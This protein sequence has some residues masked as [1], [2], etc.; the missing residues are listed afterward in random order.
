MET[1]PPTQRAMHAARMSVGLGALAGA[2]EL[3]SISTS[4]RQPLGSVDVLVLGSVMVTVMALFSVTL[5]I[6]TAWVHRPLQGADAAKAMAL[7]LGLVGGGLAAW[8]LWLGAVDI[9]AREQP[10]GAAAMAVMPFGFVGVVYY[11]ARYLLRRVQAGHHAP[12][13]WSVTSA[14][15]TLVIVVGCALVYPYRDTG[16]GYA[17]EGD[18]SAVVITVDGL[19]HDALAMSSFQRVG[20]GGVLFRN[21]VT[22]TPQ[23]GP[24]NATVWTGLHPLRH[25][26]LAPGTKLHRGHRTVA[27]VVAKEGYATAGFV[28]D[29]AVGAAM[30]FSQGFGLFDDDLSPW[31]AGLGHF[32][33]ARVAVTQWPRL[34]RDRREAGRTVDRFLPWLASHS[35]TPF[36]AWLHLAD[37]AHAQPGSYAE[38]ADEVDRAIN[39]VLDALE[40]LGLR[41]DTVLVLAG[42]FGAGTVERPAPNLFEQGVRVPL[43]LSL[44]GIEVRVPE[45]DAQVRL[46]DIAPT[47]LEALAFDESKTSEGVALGVYG[48]GGRTATMWCSL[49]AVD[50]GRIQFGM[51]N[52]GVKLIDAD[53]AI[54]MYDVSADPD[55]TTDLSKEQPAVLERAMQLLATE[56]AALDRLLE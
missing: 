42:T 30:D 7:H 28:S 53:G 34:M 52:S 3:V 40:A 50:A 21:A 18:R 37:P 51:R 47:L 33:L 23:S 39:R 35:D 44:P 5:A 19:R 22:P 4:S 29:R 15:I 31:V 54:V 56:R 36:L 2:F 32:R 13:P 1:W 38:A 10:I 46:M 24:A 43:A 14:A 11:N 9:L 8:Y 20:Q 48:E 6:V 25:Q 49:V 16:G 12:V 41:E 55:E 45:V 17:L 26:H 27:E